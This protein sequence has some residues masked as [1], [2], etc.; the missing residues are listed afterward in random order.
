MVLGNT[1]DLNTEAKWN[2][3]TATELYFSTDLLHIKDSFNYYI[4]YMFRPSV[5]RLGQEHRL[6]EVSQIVLLDGFVFSKLILLNYYCSNFEDLQ[7]E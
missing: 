2:S 6:N 5:F 3:N 1:K 7:G 4:K